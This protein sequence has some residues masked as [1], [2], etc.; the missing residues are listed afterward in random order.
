[1]EPE[2]L[3]EAVDFDVTN[4]EAGV[5]PEFEFPCELAEETDDPVVVTPDES[6]REFPDEDS[7]M[8]FSV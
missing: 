8:L 7:P 2:R 3:D 1:M 6:G 4:E 5:V